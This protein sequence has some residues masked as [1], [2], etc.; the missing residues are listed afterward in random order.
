LKIG[1]YQGNPMKIETISG[2]GY[3][4]AIL[5]GELTISSFTSLTPALSSI[6]QDHP[7]HDLVLDMSDIHSAD[8][9]AAR[10]LLNIKKK[11]EHAHKRLYLLKP[12]K[13]QRQLFLSGSPDENIEILDSLTI[14]QQNADNN[15]YQ[16][17]LPFTMEENGLLRL[18]LGCG[19]CGSTNVYGYLLEKNDYTWNW[20]QNDFFPLCSLKSGEQ[21]DYFGTLPIVCSDCLAASIDI[22]NFNIFDE[23]NHIRHH[24]TY[25]DQTRLFLS[26][27]IKKRKKLMEESEV[28]MNESF[29]KCP[30]SRISSYYCYILAES[31]ARIA[32]VDRHDDSMF[33][34]GFLNYL[35]LLFAEQEK[36]PELIDGC[37]TWLT[38]AL[39]TPE[40][41]DPAQLSQSHFI[42]FIAT[43]SL[44]KYK[45][46]N[47]IME[48]YTTLMNLHGSISGSSS[49]IASPTFWYNRA[50]E[51]W[52]EEINKKSS[53]IFT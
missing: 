11:L 44:G 37:R 51:I 41:Y 8:P 14:L 3:Q 52:K 22:G 9:N 23:N 43:I 36:K 42:I 6:I 48:N 28:L 12:D 4:C 32:A 46:I 29:F 34:V 30:R 27:T 39:A 5:H 10:L 50:E 13:D 25:N 17:Y 33:T 2:N 40:R 7:E 15:L 20:P 47:K 24:S 35:A 1:E 38:Q 49:T 18:R 16:K 53:A 21:F 45:E 19:V 31:C 26:K